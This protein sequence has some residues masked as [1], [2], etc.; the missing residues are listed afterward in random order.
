MFNKTSKPISNDK[1]VIAD[2]D[3]L[4]AERVAFK[5][6][7]KTHYLESI[8]TMQFWVFANELARFSEMKDAKS[9]T[10]DEIVDRY[11]TLFSSVCK[12]ISA[13]DV[14]T[15][16]AVQLAALLNLIL[17]TVMGKT[18]GEATQ[19]KKLIQSMN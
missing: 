8:S 7:G 11:H 19:K 12:T 17:E 16:S 6:H 18:Q 2:L 15:M 3:A 5:I 4:I 9:L 13:K 10:V 1:N 14:E